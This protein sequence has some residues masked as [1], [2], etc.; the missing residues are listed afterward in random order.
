VSCFIMIEIE[1]EHLSDP[2]RHQNGGMYGTDN[3]S[4]RNF[5]RRKS[6]ACIYTE[7]NHTDESYS[8]E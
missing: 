8:N 3:W 2:Q 4:D 6:K 5:P 1:M 7:I